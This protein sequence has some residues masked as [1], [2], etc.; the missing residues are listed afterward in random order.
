M[1]CGAMAYTFFK[2]QGL[3]VGKSK[4]ELDF[5]EYAKGLLK[6]ANG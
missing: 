6:K 1:I 2:A 4:C 3:E 5:V